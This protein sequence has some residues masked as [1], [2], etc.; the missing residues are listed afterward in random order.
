MTEPIYP[1]S[2]QIFTVVSITPYTGYEAVF[3]G[4]SL[5]CI[6]Y[7]QDTCGFPSPSL[8]SLNKQSDDQYY[9]AISTLLATI[10]KKGVH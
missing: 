3:Q 2:E 8:Y 7:L 4:S 1:Q 5:E 6:E 9:I 10:V